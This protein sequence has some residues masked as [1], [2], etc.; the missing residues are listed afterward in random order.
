MV[1]G[2]FIHEKP[3]NMASNKTGTAGNQYIT[4]K[5][6]FHKIISYIFNDTLTYGHDAS[7]LRCN[8]GLPLPK[9]LDMMHH[10]QTFP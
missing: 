10:V 6:F 4:L 3:Y 9:R 8:S 1:I 2:I 7:C 5:T